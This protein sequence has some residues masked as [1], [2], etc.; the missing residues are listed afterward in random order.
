MPL[1]PTITQ[2][3]LKPNG[4]NGHSGYDC[5]SKREKEVLQLVARG[6]SNKEIAHTL[7]LSKGTVKIHVSN[8][9][10]KLHMA[11]RTEAAAWAI[12]AGLLTDETNPS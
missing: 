8:I 6:V 3:L 10:A 4:Q 2:Y 11:S 12:Q 1:H 7:Q 9:L 5:L